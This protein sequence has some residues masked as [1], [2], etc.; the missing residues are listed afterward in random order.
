MNQMKTLIEKK[1]HLFK[2]F[3]ANGRL[4]INRV[5]L[6]QP[7]AE[8]INIIKS[9]N[10]NFYNKL[11]K[12]L[13]SSNTSNKTYWSLM[14][15]FVNGKKA[16][17]ISPLLFNNNL[18]SNFKEKANIFYDFFAQQCQ[19][20]ANN[21]ILPTNQIFYTQNR[22]RDFNID[23]GK[24][25]KLINGLNP[26][27]AHGHDEIYIRMVKSCNLTITKSLSIIYKNCLQERVFPD[28]WFKGNII[29]VHKEKL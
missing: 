16:P 9:S 5:R 20:I 2:S 7:G 10:E 18:I 4:T 15:S 14:K 13:K 11:V 1:N 12:K 17:I 29:G 25:S 6:Q 24:I 22:L 19:P 3:M 8:L 21:S 28:E 23:Y 27:K 26:H